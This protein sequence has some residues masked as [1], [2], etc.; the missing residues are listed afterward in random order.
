M[1]TVAALVT[2]CAVFKRGGGEQEAVTIAEV[3]DPIPASEHEA[4]L[5]AQV[6]GALEREQGDS[7]PGSAEVIAR[8]PYYYREYAEFPSGTTAFDLAFNERDSRTSPYAAEVSYDK[9]RYST[10]LHRSREDAR[11]DQNFLRDTGSET[12]SYEFRSGE[13]R[14]I[15]SLFVADRTEELVNGEWTQVNE[16]VERTI[17]GEEPSDQGWFDRTMNRLQFWK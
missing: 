10:R 9:V 15:G 8:R 17:A 11:A 3:A 5:R 4:R 7:G 6:E 14:K 1:A 2:G 13:W 16:T 12:V